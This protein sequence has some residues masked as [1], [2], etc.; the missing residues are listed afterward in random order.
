[1]FTLSLKPLI[2]KFHVVIWQISSKNCT[3]VRA[4]L[5]ARLFFL[6]QPIRSLFSGNGND[7]FRYLHI[8][9]EKKQWLLRAARLL[10]KPCNGVL[11]KRCGFRPWTLMSVF[12]SLRSQGVHLEFKKR[13]TTSG[14]EWSHTGS[15][16]CQL[17][18][19]GPHHARF[20]QWRWHCEDMGTC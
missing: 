9:A 4:A 1:M 18:F 6:I 8:Y 19:K 13:K 10:S 5:A 2:F 3:Q 14:V 16:L 12:V 11:S 7:D 17:E 20:S 15:E